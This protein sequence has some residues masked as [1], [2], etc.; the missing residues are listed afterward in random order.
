MQSLPLNV[1]KFTEFLQTDVVIFFGLLP[2][3]IKVGFAMNRAVRVKNKHQ[4]FLP[5][6]EL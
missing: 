6:T 3:D 4:S 1:T 2:S 5:G